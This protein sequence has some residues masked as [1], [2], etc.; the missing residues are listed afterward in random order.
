MRRVKIL[1]DTK[2]VGEETRGELG[3][4]GPRPVS[5]DHFGLGYQLMI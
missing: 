2:S 1:G 5:P 4:D 3:W